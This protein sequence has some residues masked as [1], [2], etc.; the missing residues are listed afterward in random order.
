M[1]L[2]RFVQR[3]P[4]VSRRLRLKR[5]EAVRARLYDLR[6]HECE[7]GEGCEGCK[8]AG[9]LEVE[10]KEGTVEGRGNGNWG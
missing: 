5:L 8:E 9:L 10:L 7:G 1:V 3:S 4:L 6:F 2:K